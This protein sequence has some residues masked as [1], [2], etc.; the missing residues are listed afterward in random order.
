M[1]FRPTSRAQR[2]AVRDILD[3]LYS[4]A[5]RKTLEACTVKA[6]KVKATRKPKPSRCK[7]KGWTCLTKWV[8]GWHGALCQNCNTYAVVII[9][10]HERK[11]AERRDSGLVDIRTDRFNAIARVVSGPK[12]PI[13]DTSA[14]E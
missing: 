3:E 2:V 7:G 14:A 6:V 12:R 4:G 9:D 8:G 13:D 5:E 11:R 10:A 1:A